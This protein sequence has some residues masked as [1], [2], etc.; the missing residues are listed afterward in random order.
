MFNFLKSTLTQTAANSEAKALVEEFASQ[1]SQRYYSHKLEDFT[2]G[3]KY[4]NAELELQREVVFTMLS[5]LEKNP[6]RALNHTDNRQAWDL[7]WKK[8]WKMRE[9]LLAMLKRKLPFSEKDVIAILEWSVNRTE[10]HTYY[11]GIPQMIKVVGDYLN[12]NEISDDLQ[13]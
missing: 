12:G 9:L 11:R 13:K 2:A 10:N 4:Q 5:W 1:E 3:I 8:Q 6:L 7:Q